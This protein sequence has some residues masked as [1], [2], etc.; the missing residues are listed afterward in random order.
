VNRHHDQRK[1]YKKQHLIGAGLQVQRFSPLSSSRWEHGSIQAGMAQ[2]EL[3][4]LCLHPKAASGRLTSRQLGWGSYTHTRSDISIPTRS[5]LF[6]QGHTFRWCHS[7]VQGYTNHHKRDIWHLSLASAYSGMCIHECMNTHIHVC[8][9]ALYK[10]TYG[11]TDWLADRH[12][13]TAVEGKKLRP[14][15]TTIH[16]LPNCFIIDFII[17]P[18]VSLEKP[19]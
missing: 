1:S 13:L 9:H 14:I 17:E 4:I 18:L 19:K 5:H 11:Q 8:M 15:D 3:R 6:Q 2:E 10:Q 16:A 7:L 12:I